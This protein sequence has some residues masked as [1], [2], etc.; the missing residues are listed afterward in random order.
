MS[1]ALYLTISP[2]EFLLVRN[3]YL[4]FT[5]FLF[6][7]ESINN[8]TLLFVIDLSS[9]FIACF[10]WKEEHAE[11]FFNAGPNTDSETEEIFEEILSFES[12][13]ILQTIEHF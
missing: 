3:T 7:G 9:S 13:N 12:V 6:F 10:H 11:D 8:R 5:I 1:R 4:F 2:A